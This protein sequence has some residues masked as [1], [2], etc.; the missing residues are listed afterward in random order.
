[1]SIF[2]KNNLEKNPIKGGTPA[3]ENIITVKK[4]K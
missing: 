3:R 4:N 1:M 2:S